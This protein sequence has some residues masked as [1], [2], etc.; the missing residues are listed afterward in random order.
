MRA[1][2][3]FW[4]LSSPTYISTNGRIFMDPL[5]VVK[6]HNKA[7]KKSKGSPKTSVAL[8]LLTRYGLSDTLKALGFDENGIGFTEYDL[9]NECRKP[10]WVNNL[11]LSNPEEYLSIKIKD[12][13][14][15]NVKECYMSD[16]QLKNKY[17][18]RVVSSILNAFRAIKRCNIEFI[19]SG[20]NFWKF[21]LGKCIYGNDIQ[22]DALLLNHVQ[23]HLISLSTYL[24][25]VTFLQLY[26]L[27][28]TSKD[29]YE[30][31]MEVFMHLDEW[32]VNKTVTNLYEKRVGVLDLFLAEIVK[33]IFRSCYA[34]KQRNQEITPEL[35]SRLLKINSKSITKIYVCDV[36]HTSPSQYND[37]A[38]ISILSKKSRQPANQNSK[39]KQLQENILNSPDHRFDPSFGGVESLFTIPSSNP[40]VGGSINPFAFIDNNGCFIKSDWASPLDELVKYLPRS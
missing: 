4:R 2:L 31:F 38:L 37:N 13:I 36:L 15:I 5:I 8:Y 18:R 7:T 22:K 1:P 9:Y 20:I 19:N 26:S 24:D 29:I 39:K 34:I 35:V 16:D 17:F 32:L 14:Y 23:N 25:P 10:T 12:D 33:K 28:I 6:A 30:L 40:G 21:L 3:H 27:G 11:S